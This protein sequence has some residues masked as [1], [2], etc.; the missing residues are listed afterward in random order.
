MSCELRRRELRCLRSR[1][2][3]TCGTSRYVFRGQRSAA[4][5]ADLLRSDRSRKG[6]LEDCLGLLRFSWRRRI[7]QARELV[8]LQCS[9]PLISFLSAPNHSAHVLLHGSQ[10]YWFRPRVLHKVGA[11][12]DLSISLLGGAVT[13]RL[14]FFI[15]PAAMA[16]LGHEEGP[17]SW[18]HF[19]LSERS[20]TGLSIAQ[21]RGTSSEALE[22]RASS[23]ASA[24]TP[25]ALL[26]R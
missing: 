3:S 16:K 15:S 5:R 9:S 14:P 24:S 21:A 19:A 6:P 10:R 20:L 25:A 1:P 12:V 26:R 18:P 13:S 11:P 7:H 2:W 8:C 4:Q 17:F 22:L 23:K